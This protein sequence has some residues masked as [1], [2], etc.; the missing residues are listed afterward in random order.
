MRVMVTI[1]ATGGIRSRCDA[2]HRV[3]DRDGPLQ[4]GYRDLPQHLRSTWSL[5]PDTDGRRVHRCE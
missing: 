5:N 1:K 2:K 4:R 3:A